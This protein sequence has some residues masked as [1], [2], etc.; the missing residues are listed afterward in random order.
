MHRHEWY[1]KLHD[2]TPAIEVDARDFGRTLGL[3]KLFGQLGLYSGMSSR[4]APL[5]DYVLDAIIAAN[6]TDTQDVRVVEDEIRELVKDCFGDTFDCAVVNTCEAGLRVAIETLISPPILRRGD[7]YRARLLFPYGEDADWGAAYGRPFPPKYKNVSV[8][9]SVSAGE[10]GMEAKCLPNLDT[11]FVPFAGAR[12]EVHGIRQNVVP[13]LLDVTPDQTLEQLACIA[14]R[15]STSFAGLLAIGYDTPGYGHGQKDE[16]GNSRLMRGFGELARRYDVPFIIDSASSL[17]IVGRGPSDFNADVQS[18][19]MDKV[20]GAPTS[21]LIIG[22]DVPML[23]IR[24]SLGLAGERFGHVS[25]HGKAVFSA[26]DPGRTA[27]V[28]LLASLKMLRDEADR[29]RQPIDALYDIAVA[30]F[31][32]LTDYASD[33]TITKSYHLGGLEVNYLRSWEHG[34]FGIPIFTLEDLYANTNPICRALAAM[35][36]QPP[37]IYAGNM[38][39]TPGLGLLD[40]A[41][42]LIVE[43]A[44]LAIAALIRSMEIVI[45]RS[46]T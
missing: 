24:K 17:P 12:Y 13:F 33:F 40:R 7:S 20:A 11:V 21:G 44:E 6:E 5:P 38:I 18:W 1:Q 30:G 28:G 36:V 27:L 32:A 43:R 42:N 19:S 26:F 34:G 23:S 29:F 22:R 46:N 2:Q 15:H 31:E 16:E 10:L 39:L 14:E 9:R 8:D 35:G 4:P 41:G 45:E 37:P 25:S 3:G